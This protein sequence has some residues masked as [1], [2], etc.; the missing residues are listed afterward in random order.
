[1]VIK[2]AKPLD[3]AFIIKAINKKLSENHRLQ[4]LQDYYTGKQDILIRTY[5]DPTKPNNKIIVNYCK[6]IS[7]FLTSY[8]VGVPVKYEAPQIILDNLDY[9]DA[10]E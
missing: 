7:D 10:G 9:N 3:N 6:K 5:G 4:R 2:T 1:M 8:V